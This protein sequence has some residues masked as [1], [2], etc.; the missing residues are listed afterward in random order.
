MW[1][2][3][4]TCLVGIGVLGGTTTAWAEERLAPAVSVAA[5]A[6]TTSNTREEQ[7]L[8]TEQSATAKTTDQKS[9]QES[10]SVRRD[11]AITSLTDLE[12]Y[13]AKK[14]ETPYQPS[15]PLP[16]DISKL[17]YDQYRLI[18]FRHD[19][20]Y[21]GN[22]QGK[23]L[24]P[25]W[26][27]AFH[28]GFVHHDQVQLHTIE[29]GRELA[30][31]FD[32][33][34]FEYRGELSTAKIPADTGYAGVRIAGYFPGRE[35]PQEMLIFLGGSYFRMRTAE[36]VYG[37][38]CRGLAI[39]VGSNQP[40][41]FPVF[42]ELW[43]K[44]PATTDEKITLL[45]LLDS[46]SVC[47]AYEF[48][49]APGEQQSE[50]DVRAT[51]FFRSQPEKVALAPLTSM[52]MWGDGLVGPALDKRPHVHDSDGLLIQAG[53]A[54]ESSES[55]AQAETEK[56]QPRWIWRALSR[57]SYPSV[58]R[59]DV[60]QLEG[61][62]LLQR[63]T[64][65]VDYR[66]DQALYHERPSF[67]IEPTSA[68]PKGHIE[69]L[70]ID[71]AHEGVD[72]IGA[73]W[74]LAETPAVG[75]P[76]RYSYRVSCLSDADL[77]AGRHEQAR[78]VQTRIHRDPSGEQPLRVEVDFAGGELKDLALKDLDADEEISTRVVTVRAEVLAQKLKPQGNGKWTL[79]LDLRPESELPCELQVVLI[80][81]DQ[82][83]SETWS[84]L[85]AVCEPAYKIPQVYTRLE[86]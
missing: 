29:Q 62:G 39:N 21:W 44:K 47:G 36:S 40:E 64:R 55:A 67:W 14:A 32:R 84:Y 50:M 9:A 38:S 60:T 17:S 37:A 78:V 69:L 45:A 1:P 18:H 23:R 81:G 3:L 7:P 83:L 46:P 51:L 79:S 24:S 11:F 5:S 6:N 34:R 10:G 82:E 77:E 31:P 49:Y 75:E 8:N 76:F 26:F 48:T 54:D 68:W 71:G 28:R 53:S 72:N 33:S 59:I 42:R 16:R 43:I 35:D 58:S 13:A 12:R 65:Y 66:D 56:D 63:N 61:F 15:Q 30:V 74:V 25:F 70:E 57:Q 2:H 80:Q 19:L 85:C 73:Y 20:S 27:E 86:E 22:H 52:W 4:R 41:E